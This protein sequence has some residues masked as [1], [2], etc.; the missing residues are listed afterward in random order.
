MKLVKSIGITILLVL[1]I[2]YLSQNRIRDHKI[3]AELFKAELRVTSNKLLL[4]ETNLANEKIK[5]KALE[6]QVNYFKSTNADL[7]DV[8]HQNLQN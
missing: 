8:F 5:S 2:F 4:S 6:Q 3:K 7:L 1:L